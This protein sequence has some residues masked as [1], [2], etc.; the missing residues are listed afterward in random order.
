MIT[1]KKFINSFGGFLAMA[2]VTLK[3][4][5][6]DKAPSASRIKMATVGAPNVNTFKNYYSKWLKYELV[7]ESIVPDE[8]ALS[9]GCPLSSGKPYVLLRPQSKE[10]VFIRAVEIDPVPSYKAMNSWGWNAIEIICDDVDKIHSELLHSEF[11]HIGG[12]ANLM[13]GNSSIRASQ[14]I[15]PAEE[16]IY[17]T[18]ETGDRSK[19]NLPIPKSD[20]GRI[21]IMIL[22]GININEMESFYANLFNVNLKTGYRFQAKGGLISQLQN[23]PENELFNLGL[24][25]LREKGNS[26]ELD[27][28]KSNTG[29][30]KRVKGQL[31]P[32]IA[33]TT[34]SV[35]DID[36]LDVNF[37]YKLVNVYEGKRSGVFLG[38][39]GELT[40]LIEEKR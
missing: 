5:N 23:L 18:C 26:I 15:G 31:P 27:E 22:A 10:D 8:M 13:G 34:F 21:F 16:V 17:L 7:E 29:P 37:I 24:M 9:W 40:E 3:A 12:P 20:I 14:Y 11:R 1:R 30:R 36:N 6:N 28:Y 25:R 39:C 32:G 19:S 4:K 2:P 33:M 35:D 38:P